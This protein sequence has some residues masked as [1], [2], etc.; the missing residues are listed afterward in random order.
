MMVKYY[1]IVVIPRNENFVIKM[2]TNKLMFGPVVLEIA[3]YSFLVYHNKLSHPEMAAVQ[4][5]HSGDVV[6]L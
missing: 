3:W 1:G 5:L 4:E 6:I 2:S